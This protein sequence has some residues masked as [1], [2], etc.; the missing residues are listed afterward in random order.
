MKDPTV[1]ERASF[2]RRAARSSADPDLARALREL[3]DDYERVA[4]DSIGPADSL[5]ARTATPLRIDLPANEREDSALSNQ[6]II[7]LID[8]NDFLRDSLRELLESEGFHV[9]DFAS[10]S[11]FLRQPREIGFGCIVTDIQMPGMSGL[12]LIEEVRIHDKTVPIIAITAHPNA[13][14]LEAIE[15]ADA[16]FLVKPFTL[17]ELIAA[18]VDSWQ[19]RLH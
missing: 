5:L 7:Y 6:D 4:F 10:A 3:A 14:D 1:R 19:G 16:I 15:A 2:C 9:L 18:I 8:D 17:K 13:A 12:E 11:A